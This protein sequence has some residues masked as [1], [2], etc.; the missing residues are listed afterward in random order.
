MIRICHKICQAC[1]AILQSELDVVQANL[2][3]QQQMKNEYGFQ[4]GNNPKQI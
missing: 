1:L 4:E 3:W 2:T